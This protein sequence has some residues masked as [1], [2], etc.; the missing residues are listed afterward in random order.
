[1]SREI[2]RWADAEPFIARREIVTFR[3]HIPVIPGG[4]GALTEPLEK[5]TAKCGHPTNIRVGASGIT[6]AHHLRA[7]TALLVRNPFIG[8]RCEPTDFDSLIDM[9]CKP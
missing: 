1:V 9:E 4:D 5:R 8:D 3:C 2:V 6:C 7:V